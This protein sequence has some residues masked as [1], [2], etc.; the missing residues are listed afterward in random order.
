MIL[1]LHSCAGIYSVVE[2]EVLE[3]A[4]VSLPEEVNQ[5]IVLNR[6]PISLHSFEKK[7][8][9]GLERK[10]LMI[11]DTIIVR[12]VQRGLLNVFQ[13]SPIERFQ[14]IIW[15]DDRREDTT[16][17][18]DLILTRR[19]VD[20]LC[21]ENGGDAILS[22]ESYSMDYEEH[23]QSFSDSY[24]MA[25][26]YYEISS[27]ISWIIYLPGSPRPFDRYTMV[28][29]LF[30]TEVLD[31]ELIRRYSV[32]Q[33]LSEA[34]YKSGRKYGRYL[35]PVWNSTSR[36]LYK[37]REE[38]LKKAA[39]HTNRGNWD[40]AYKI[41]EGMSKGQDRTAAAKALYNMAVF[42]ELEDQLG[43]ASKLVNEALERD[44]LEL[45]INYKEEIDTRILNQKELLKQVR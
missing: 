4:S 12:S 29:T 7:D 10:H 18:E 21:M 43:F 1:L 16:L 13:E 34:F 28:D 6:A 32:A 25:T 23:V 31:G 3:P 33:M 35:V 41:W 19:E 17:L 14:Q 38:E 20:D 24:L 9:E 15:L 44:T 37:G 8:V 30:F 27:V 5:L 11:L 42:H 2:F 22:L 36:N 39:K 45:I 40:E 26:K